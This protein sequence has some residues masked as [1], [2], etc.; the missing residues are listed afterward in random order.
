VPAGHDSAASINGRVSRG[1][2]ATAPVEVASAKQHPTRSNFRFKDSDE[3]NMMISCAWYEVIE[4]PAL[5]AGLDGCD[6]SHLLVSRPTAF[7]GFVDSVVFT[8]VYIRFTAD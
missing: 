6:H 5:T 1:E 4:H 2:A 8:D 7:A 3:R